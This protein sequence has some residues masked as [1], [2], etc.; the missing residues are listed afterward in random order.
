MRNITYLYNS[1][2]LEI[3]YIFKQQIMNY[4]S[5]TDRVH[6]F[7]VQNCAALNPPIRLFEPDRARSADANG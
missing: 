3:N 2:Q 1:T 6:P 4:F 5:W 7:S